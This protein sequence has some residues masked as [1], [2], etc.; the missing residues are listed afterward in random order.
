MLILERVGLGVQIENIPL[1]HVDFLVQVHNLPTGLMAERV[2][3][4]LANYIGTFVEYDKNNKGS[5]WREYIRIKVRVDVRQPL[6]K[7]SRVKN[8]GG[9]WCIVNFKYEKLGVFCFVCGILGHSENRCATRFSLVDDDGVRA[10]SKDLR[11]EPRTRGGRQTSRWL[12]EDNGG[13]TVSEETQSQAHVSDNAQVDPTHQ[14]TTTNFSNE[15]RP[16]INQHS[17]L[18]NGMSLTI[19]NQPIIDPTVPSNAQNNNDKNIILHQPMSQHTSSHIIPQ[20]A[21]NN[22]QPTH[23]INAPD[24]HLIH[25]SSFVNSQPT[26]SMIFSPM[27]TDA[28]NHKIP[29][30]FSFN[31]STGPK[32]NLIPRLLKNN[33]THK[34]TKNGPPCTGPKTDP[35]K[36]VSNLNLETTEPMEA[37]T[38][39]KRRRDDDKDTIVHSTVSQHFLTAGPGSQA[40][41]DQ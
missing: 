5:F 24:S 25:Q 31:A 10:W 36:P 3:K 6:K 20:S 14:N 26:T 4:T 27:I 40:C 12:M 22:C 41:R 29:P 34:P 37:Q 17:L 11:A 21:P 15:N 39:K 8:Q 35:P 7:D 23:T 19:F 28:L 9:A 32:N 38:E 33:P 2:G 18:S 1:Y 13:R 16:S 30:Q